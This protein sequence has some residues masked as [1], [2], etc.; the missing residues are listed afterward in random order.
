MHKISRNLYIVS[1]LGKEIIIGLNGLGIV[2][3]F[4]CVQKRVFRFS[5]ADYS[6]MIFHGLIDPVSLY[7]LNCSFTNFFRG[8]SASMLINL[9]HEL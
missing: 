8:K 5:R 4:G 1:H 7:I 6:S 2:F 3:K 9:K